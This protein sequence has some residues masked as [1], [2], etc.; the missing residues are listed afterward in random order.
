MSNIKPK[1]LVEIDWVD[2][3]RETGWRPLSAVSVDETCMQM[4]TAGYIIYESETCLGVAQ[5]FTTERTDP[6]IDGVMRIPRV[7]ITAIRVMR[8]NGK[9]RYR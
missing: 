8:A 1:V 7:A 2:S 3:Q 5:S 9:R 6:S 4:K